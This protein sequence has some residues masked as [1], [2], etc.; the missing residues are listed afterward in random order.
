MIRVMMK[1]TDLQPAQEN[2]YCMCLEEWSDEMR[3]AGDPSILH[4]GGLVQEKGLY[5]L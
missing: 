1:I 3:E 4:T 2:M 5:L